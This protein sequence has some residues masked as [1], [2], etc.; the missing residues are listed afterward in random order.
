MPMVWLE[1]EAQENVC[2]ELYVVPSTVKERPT[3]FVWTV[4]EIPLELIVKFVSEISKK[5]FPT[6]STLTRANV[7][8]TLGKTTDSLPSLAVLAASTVGKVVPPSVES[9]ILTFAT[10][11]GAPVVAATFHITV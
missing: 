4:A 6:A 8:E 3:G 10:L 7:V 9:D 1:P 5:I 2:E 11:I